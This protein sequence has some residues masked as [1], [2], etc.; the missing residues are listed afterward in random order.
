[1]PKRKI[2]IIGPTNDTIKPNTISNLP[3]PG[4]VKLIVSQDVINYIRKRADV[5]II[6]IPRQRKHHDKKC[7]ND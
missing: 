2:A 4:L 6:K 5:P 3:D 1:M 7:H